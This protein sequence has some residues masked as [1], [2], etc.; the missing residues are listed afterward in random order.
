M[1]TFHTEVFFCEVQS[2]S[3]YSDDDIPADL[4]YSALDG[5]WNDDGDNLWGEIGEDDLL[6]DV[7]VGRMSFSNS[8]E[9]ANILNKSMMY[10]ENPILGE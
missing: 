7:S 10:Q 4:Y 5:T 8:A 6:P 2:S 9:L 1:S 3:L